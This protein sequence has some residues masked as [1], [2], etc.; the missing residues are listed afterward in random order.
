MQCPIS[1]F[2]YIWETPP[3]F[4][5]FMEILPKFLKFTV[6]EVKGCACV[7]IFFA[8]ISYC[9]F[10][11]SKV[12]PKLFEILLH[13]AMGAPNLAIVPLAAPFPAFILY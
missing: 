13:A 8:N 6:E 4:L 1:K 9:S 10:Q 7:T 2:V 11:F 12:C 5:E 3:S